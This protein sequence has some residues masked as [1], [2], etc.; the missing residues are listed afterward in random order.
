MSRAFPQN[1]ILVVVKA[2]TTENAEVATSA[3]AQ[4]LSTDKSLFPLVGQPDS[5]D[6]FERNGLLFG[7]PAE[8]RK[9]AEGLTNAQPLIAT[10]AGDPS[11]RGVM[12]T[13]SSAAEGVRAGRIK[14]EQLAWPLSLAERT[15]SD[16]LSNRPT[17]FS[18]QELL[19]GHKLPADQLRH[20]VEFSRSWIFRNCN[21]GARQPRE[22]GARRR[23]STSGANTAQ[24]SI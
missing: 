11:L 13:L 15:L 4:H 6:F 18:W 20:F 10:L 12:K 9:N 7:S 19:Q 16:V 23:I 22:F 24:R 1:G 2:P 14:L 17:T 8:V 5:G 21:P 3:L